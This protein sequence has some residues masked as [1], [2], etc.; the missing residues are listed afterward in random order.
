ME[1]HSIKVAR[2]FFTVQVY[3][4]IEMFVH[5]NT[6]FK[7]NVTHTILSIIRSYRFR[8]FLLS[9]VE[10]QTNLNLQKKQ[11]KNVETPKKTRIFLSF[12]IYFE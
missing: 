6:L 5:S 7:I 4:N 11:L 12:H 1:I 8:F 3:L 10:L 2:I 9:I